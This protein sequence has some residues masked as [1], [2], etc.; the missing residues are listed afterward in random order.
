MSAPRKLQGFRFQVNKIVLLS[1]AYFLLST[2]TGCEA[3][4][5]KFTRKPKEVRKEEP[6]IQPE[7]YPD[8]GVAKDRLY[9]DYFL[10]WQAWADELLAHLNEKANLKKQKECAY[11]ALDNL[12]KM[13]SLLNEEKAKAFEPLVNEFKTVSDIVFAGRL[14]SADFDYLRLKVERIK[15]KVHR[16]FIFS[17][18]Q[19]DLQ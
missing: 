16:N 7:I 6:I 1:T 12:F 10:F 11:E 8:K 13:R 14:V 15:A 3:F 2:L 4:V 19:K 9:K 5:R 18:V 17:K